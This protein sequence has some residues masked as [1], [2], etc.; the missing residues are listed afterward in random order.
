MSDAKPDAQPKKRAWLWVTSVATLTF[1]LGG[2]I[3]W[4]FGYPANLI[5]G[6]VVT[7]C[8]TILLAAVTYWFT[9]RKTKPSKQQDK[10]RLLINKRSKL[11]ALHFKKMLAVQK[12]R[13]K[14]VS[15]VAMTN[16]SIYCS[17]TIHAR[18]KASL[19]RWVMRPIK[20]TILVTTLSSPFCFG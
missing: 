3:T 10:Q 14:S 9:S 17:A 2:S 18:I 11:L 1:A 13:K 19:L 16:R 4:L 6:A 7:V 5:L 20:S 15:I 12:K 8:A